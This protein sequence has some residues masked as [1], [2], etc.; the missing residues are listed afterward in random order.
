EQDDDRSE[1]EGE[2]ALVGLT[3]HQREEL[4]EN[5]AV[6]RATLNKVRKLS[7]AVVHLMTIAL[8]AW[9]KVCTTHQ[10]PVRVIPR[11]VTTRWN[12]T[13]NMLK[14]ALQ[15]RPAIDNITANK[16]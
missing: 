3:S 2:D 1:G 8:P 4:I 14:M 9:C 12:S 6:V 7:F 11:D 5:T 15:Y 16:S 13:F 10:L